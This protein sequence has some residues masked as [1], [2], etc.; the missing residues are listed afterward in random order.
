MSDAF[1]CDRCQTVCDYQ[2][3]YVMEVASAPY[4]DPL[5]FE[6]DLCES[7]ARDAKQWVSEK[8]VRVRPMVDQGFESDPHG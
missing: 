2:S 6:A 7:C 8:P 5:S 1:K 4:A 3:G